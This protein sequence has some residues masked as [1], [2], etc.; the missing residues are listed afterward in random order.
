MAALQTASFFAE[1]VS[2]VFLVVTFE[3]DASAV[4]SVY[5][6]CLFCNNIA[7]AI[8]LFVILWVYYSFVIKPAEKVK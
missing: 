7:S 6:G 3:K 1:T 4:S 2:G 5:I 8:A